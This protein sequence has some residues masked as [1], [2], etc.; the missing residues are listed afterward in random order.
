MANI[1][2]FTST[3]QNLVGD[4]SLDYKDFKWDISNCNTTIDIT[5]SLVE[6]IAELENEMKEIRRIM[7][8]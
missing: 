4:D 8:I 5:Q 2:Y 1:G 3:G 7:G 6:R